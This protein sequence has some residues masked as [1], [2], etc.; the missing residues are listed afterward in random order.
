[1]L[2]RNGLKLVIEIAY[3]L[4][5]DQQAQFAEGLNEE[6]IKLSDKGIDNP[7]LDTV[8][9]NEVYNRLFNPAL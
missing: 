6:V 7:V 4:R 3:T 2:T 9:V 1:M 8:E 5:T